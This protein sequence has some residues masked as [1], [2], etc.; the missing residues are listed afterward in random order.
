MV[1]QVESSLPN[2]RMSLVHSH[3]TFSQMCVWVG[4]VPLTD[5]FPGTF[6]SLGLPQAYFPRELTHACCF[7]GLF[8]SAE[9]VP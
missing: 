1:K 4:V 9:T 3:S 6:L 5:F 7:F 2:C 8:W